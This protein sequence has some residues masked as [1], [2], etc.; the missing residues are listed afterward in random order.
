M[1]N[2]HY[3]KFKKE[4]I[5]E[6]KYL[7][8]GNLQKYYK[9]GKI[10]ELNNQNNEILKDNEITSPDKTQPI[11]NIQSKNNIKFLLRLYFYYK[12]FKEKFNNPNICMQNP[13]TGYI[14]NKDLIE[15]YK[16]YYNYNELKNIFDYSK[17][18]DSNSIEE[19]EN[20]LENLP[21]IYIKEIIEKD[22]NPSTKDKFCN[23]IQKINLNL[24]HDNCVVL[25]EKLINILYN[26]NENIQRNRNKLKIQYFIHDKKLIIIYNN[27]INIGIIDDNCI[28]K[29][30]KRIHFDTNEELNHILNKIKKKE[31][32]IFK[33][34]LNQDF[35]EP[36]KSI[37]TKANDIKI[38]KGKL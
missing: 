38:N 19:L 21:N 17:T 5:I 7:I 4:K 24:Y 37:K 12:S 23:Y 25:N 16:E 6:N 11:L 27:N 2:N 30:E 31:F 10:I 1:K 14:I 15:K 8:V 26:Y 35:N 28:F 13:E 36:K 22:D 32:D 9:I 34:I 33:D 29:L 3:N 20:L 18:S